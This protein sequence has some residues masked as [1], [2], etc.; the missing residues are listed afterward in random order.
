M[1]K[2]KG[3]GGK[4]EIAGSLEAE[5]EYP[6]SH[7]LRSINVAGPIAIPSIG[8]HCH[9]LDWGKKKPQLVTTQSHNRI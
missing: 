9:S 8:E 5:C 6:G 3:G 4:E 2:G 7:T 1:V